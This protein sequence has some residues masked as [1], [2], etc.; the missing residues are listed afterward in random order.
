MQIAIATFP[1]FTAL[2]GIGP[3][4]VLQRIPSLDVVFVGHARGEVRSD[5]G[6][7]GIVADATFE[8]IAR[9]EVVVMPGGI[10][11]RE[12]LG[13]ERVLDWVRTA[14]ETSTLTTSVCSGSLVLAAAGLLNGL[15][16]AS[17]WSVYEY[18]E[19]LGA[20]PTPQRVVEHLDRRIVTAAG[21]SA[22]L[23]MA[24]RLA[25]LLVDDVAAQAAQLL[26]EYD[27]Q[28]PFDAGSRAKA[29]EAV[30]ARVTEYAAQRS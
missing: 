5:N 1:R 18:L 24:L 21:V 16:A 25:E 28:P 30:L 9:P 11:T 29:G 13:D 15:E 17:H 12:L 14:H 7:L 4:E 27:P 20:V 22:G 3:Y 19:L 6:M 26:I 10:G 8:E 2:D 23:D